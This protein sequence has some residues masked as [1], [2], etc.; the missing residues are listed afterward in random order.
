MA[1]RKGE[2]ELFKAWFP[3]S[4]SFASLERAMRTAKRAHASISSRGRTSSSSC[5]ATFC[6]LLRPVARGLR[7]YWMSPYERG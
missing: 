7:L 3:R 6:R 4:F 2:T 5:T 1:G